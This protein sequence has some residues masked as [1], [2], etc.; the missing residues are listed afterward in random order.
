MKNQ[1]ENNIV[2][3]FR[4]AK[5]DII[6]LQNDVIELGQ[7]QKRI[8]ELLDELKQSQMELYQ[9][10]TSVKRSASPRKTR[11]KPVRRI[12]TRTVVKTV[13]VAKRAHKRFV[14][15]KGG[16]KFHVPTCPFAQNIKPKHKTTFKSKTK[17][18]NEG[19]KPCKCVK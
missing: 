17:A 19:F 14:A 3:S 11:A 12:R 16:K 9:K 15:P 18:L 13:S 5:T 2:N 8:V 10:I 4:L 7:T 1:L 6:K